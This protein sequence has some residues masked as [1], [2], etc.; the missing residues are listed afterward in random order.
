MRLPPFTSST[1]LINVKNTVNKSLI[2]SSTKHT[3]DC[4]F[5]RKR[6]K[7]STLKVKKGLCE[8]RTTAI[9][10]LQL[11]LMSAHTGRK[12]GVQRGEGV[13]QNHTKRL[14]YFPD[15]AA[16]RGISNDAPFISWLIRDARGQVVPL[17]SLSTSP[18]EH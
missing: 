5:Q 18:R 13:E 7:K 9:K 15:N 17:L 10:R 6:R 12:T 16:V 11:F 4:F 14:S 8:L 3:L 1:S 2:C